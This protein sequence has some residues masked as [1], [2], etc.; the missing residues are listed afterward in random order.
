MHMLIMQVHDYITDCLLLTVRLD[1]MLSPNDS[2][3]SE[4]IINYYDN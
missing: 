1:F 3:P 2:E 4:Q